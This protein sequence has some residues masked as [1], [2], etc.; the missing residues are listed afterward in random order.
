MA[1]WEAFQAAPQRVD[2]LIAD[3]SMPG[4]TGD[5]LIQRCRRI[6][7]DL[8]VILC[9]GSEQQLSEADAR[10]QGITDFVLK[11]LMIHDLAYMIR[12]TLD[13][14]VSTASV[15]S[16][17]AQSLT[18]SEVSSEELNAVGPRC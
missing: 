2:L 17:S 9:T 4:M 8:P 14:P 13:R 11:P 18:L 1:A 16:A 10:S 15:P 3:Q 5:R 6:R 12:R 7:P